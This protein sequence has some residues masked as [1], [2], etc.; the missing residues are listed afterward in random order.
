MRAVKYPHADI[1]SFLAAAVSFF[2]FFLVSKKSCPG[3]SCSVYWN[4]LPCNGINRRNDK[5]V[6]K[7]CHKKKNSKEFTRKCGSMD[8]KRNCQRGLD[9]ADQFGKYLSDKSK[10]IAKTF[11][12]E[13]HSHSMNF[14]SLKVSLA[15]NAFC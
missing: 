9:K 11:C 8:Q 7:K 14:H 1:C 10:W 13:N 12:T 4:H 6:T 2:F 3:L 5:C 15:S